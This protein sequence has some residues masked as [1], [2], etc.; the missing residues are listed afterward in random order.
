MLN[1]EKNELRNVGC[2]TELR[3]IN[4]EICYDFEKSMGVLFN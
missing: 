1:T 4:W 2:M 3:N